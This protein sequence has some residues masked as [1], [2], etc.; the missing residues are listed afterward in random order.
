MRLRGLAN[1]EPNYETWV[2]SSNEAKS[3]AEDPAAS[4]GADVHLRA[5]RLAAVAAC[6]SRRGD[7][8]TGRPRRRPRRPYPEERPCEGVRQAR[9]RQGSFARRGRAAAAR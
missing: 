1:L 7:G 6:H 4:A 5:A 3:D 9:P 2:S 8:S